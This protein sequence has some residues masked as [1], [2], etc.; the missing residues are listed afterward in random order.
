MEWIQ[1]QIAKI[2]FIGL[3][4]AVILFVSGTAREISWSASSGVACS[5]TSGDLCVK[6]TNSLAYYAPADAARTHLK[7][8]LENK[9]S[10]SCTNAAVL[11][12]RIE[13]SSNLLR[14]LTASCSLSAKKP[15]A[16]GNRVAKD[17]I[18]LSREQK[19]SAKEM[20]ARLQLA[21][22][23]FNKGC[24]MEDG[25]SCALAAQSPLVSAKAL[26]TNYHRGCYELN[27][28]TACIGLAEYFKSR[29]EQLNARHAV[30]RVCKGKV[31][32]A[33]SDLRDRLID[34]KSVQLRL[35]SSRRYN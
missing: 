1:K 21:L 20:R 23:H 10:D 14:A 2:I 11:F 30:D 25:E 33:C 19:P 5:I 34:E 15:C 27:H 22:T 31:N 6:L 28:P 3:A 16:Q 8:C 32:L 12:S 7:N 13:D 9:V 29:G 35:P 4:A 24:E 17:W 26:Y 18:K